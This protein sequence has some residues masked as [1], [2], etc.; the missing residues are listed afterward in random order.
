MYTGIAEVEQLK[1]L[2]NRVYNFVEGNKDVNENGECHK[3][4]EV[5]ETK[6]GTL[7]SRKIAADEEALK[8]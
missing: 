1:W 8:S 5:K 7:N 2:I 4:I 3:P 6:V